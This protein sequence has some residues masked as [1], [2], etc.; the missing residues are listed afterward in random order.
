MK[1]H[2]HDHQFL[3]IIINQSFIISA[4]RFVKHRPLRVIEA[5]IVGMISSVVA[6][7]L[8]YFKPDCAPVGNINTT[9]VLQVNFSRQCSTMFCSS[10]Y[11]FCM[12]YIHS[13]YPQLTHSQ[14]SLSS[15]NRLFQLQRNQID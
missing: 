7:N 12:P 10:I 5:I 2:N 6:F 11:S 13:Q 1:H 8:I 4:I 9:D 3:W 15:L 14:I